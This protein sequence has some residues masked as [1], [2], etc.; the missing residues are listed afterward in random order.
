VSNGDIVFIE[1]VAESVD[2]VL[3]PLLGRNTIK[4]G[5]YVLKCSVDKCFYIRILFIIA[6]VIIF[7]KK[8]I[9]NRYHFYNATLYVNFQF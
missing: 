8:K 4:K 7:Q 3:E 1:N 5:R 6:F 2:P 9:E